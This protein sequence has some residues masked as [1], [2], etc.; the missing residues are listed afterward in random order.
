[1]GE[2]D[3][4]REKRLNPEPQRGIRECVRAKT[5]GFVSSSDRQIRLV[6]VIQ[7]PLYPNDR[8]VDA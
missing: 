4:I 2:G 5:V 1:M 6:N 8:I 3:A 7:R